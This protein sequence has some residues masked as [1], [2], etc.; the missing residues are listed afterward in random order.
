MDEVRKAGV[1]QT[2]GSLKYKPV[3]EEI[4]STMPTDT[5]TGSG[6]PH[7]RLICQGFVLKRVS[8]YS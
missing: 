5:R 8:P 2:S 4:S 6:T 1:P 7:V 3:S